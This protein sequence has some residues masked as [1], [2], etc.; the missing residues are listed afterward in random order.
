VRYLLDTNV[1]SEARKKPGRRD[2]RFHE[3]I[4]GVAVAD[5]AISVITLGEVLAGVIGMERRDAVQGAALRRWYSSGVLAQFNRRLLPVT[6]AIAEV[7]AQLQVPDPRPKAE[8][9]IAATAL[10]H[11]LILVTRNVTDFERTGV[12]WLNPWTGESGS[13]CH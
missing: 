12:A 7:E 9:I 10:C 6:R 8:A 13:G 2:P 3:W 11:D 1:L 5:A 4:E